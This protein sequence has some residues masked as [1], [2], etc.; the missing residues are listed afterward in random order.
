[1]K[2]ERDTEFKPFKIVIETEQEQRLFKSIVTTFSKFSNH[3][4]FNIYANEGELARTLKKMLDDM[5]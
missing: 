3:N 1:M 2:I 5:D 4:H